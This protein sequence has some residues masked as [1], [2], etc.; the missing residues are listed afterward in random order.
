MLARLWTSP[1]SEG[2]SG[3]A[4]PGSECRIHSLVG[5]GR[6]SLYLYLLRT[7]KYSDPKCLFGRDLHL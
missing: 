7:R 1:T 6:C 4:C 3:V 2:D 5:K